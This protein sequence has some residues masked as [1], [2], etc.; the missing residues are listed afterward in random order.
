MMIFAAASLT[1][2]VEAL[3]DSF[4]LEKGVPASVNVAASSTLSRQIE[5]GAHADVFISADTSWADRLVRERVASSSILLPVGN[6]IVAAYLS[7][8]GSARSFAGLTNVS[9]V[10]MGDPTH[11]PAGEYARRTLVCA[12]LW[13]SVRPRAVTTIDVRAALAA[14]VSG[15]VDGAIV[16][17]S[18]VARDRRFVAAPAPDS[19]RV[20]V[21]YRA[22]IPNA[23]ALRGAASDFVLYISSPQRRSTWERF[24]FRWLGA[25]S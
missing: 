17:A 25:I 20:A 7:S 16:Y 9:R 15:S 24:G 2:V 3:A 6:V 5:F 12:A 19:C 8:E 13:D 22:V 10:A 11:V 21:E 18:D 14:L 1:D 23:A 4:S